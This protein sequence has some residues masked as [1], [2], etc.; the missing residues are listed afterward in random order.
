MCLVKD[1]KKSSEIENPSLLTFSYSAKRTLTWALSLL[2]GCF[3][4]S[5]LSCYKYN[6]YQQRDKLY[7]K[8][9]LYLCITINKNIIS[10]NSINFLHTN[11]LFMHFFI[12]LHALEKWD[13]YGVM[14]NR[15]WKKWLDSRRP[16]SSFA[17]VLIKIHLWP[18][19]RQQKFI[20]FFWQPVYF[21]DC[22]KYKCGNRNSSG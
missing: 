9:W 7:K 21:Q 19:Y 3:N 10:S 17:Q 20:P 4:K 13:L 5:F 14:A 1:L 18:C 8:L 11:R 2:M 12:F 15:Q 22:R 16:K 6:Y